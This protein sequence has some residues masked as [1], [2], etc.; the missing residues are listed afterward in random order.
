MIFKL[1]GA[2]TVIIKTKAPA[3]NNRGFNVTY[4]W[5]HKPIL[6]AFFWNRYMYGNLKV[7]FLNL[8][9]MSWHLFKRCQLFKTKNP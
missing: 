1:K 4:H 9:V 5:K 6:F 8:N 3:K 2:S 7:L